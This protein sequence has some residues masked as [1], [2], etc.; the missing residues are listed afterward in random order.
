MG[1]RKEVKTRVK[2][3]R[4]GRDG[5]KEEK[6]IRKGERERRKEGEKEEK[7]SGRGKKCIR[8]ERGKN[9]S[10]GLRGLV[11]GHKAGHQPLLHPGLQLVLR[12]LNLNT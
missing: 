10:P 7:R 2:K 8:G 3:R 6:R 9:V 5:E 1:Q 12:Q 11:G 4:K